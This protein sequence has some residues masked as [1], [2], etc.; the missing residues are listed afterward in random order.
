[1][2]KTSSKKTLYASPPF[3]CYIVHK[4]HIMEKQWAN[5]NRIFSISEFELDYFVNFMINS[6]YISVP[7]KKARN[8]A[9]TQPSFWGKILI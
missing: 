9:K 1:M 4:E 5:L 2:Y 3:K 7:N 6:N 8:R